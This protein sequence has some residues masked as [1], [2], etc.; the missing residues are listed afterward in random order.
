MLLVFN[1]FGPQF[2]SQLRTEIGRGPH[3]H[4]CPWDATDSPCSYSRPLSATCESGLFFS[5]RQC[6]TL[7]S[8]KVRPLDRGH[9]CAC[10]MVQCHRTPPGPPECAPFSAATTGPSWFVDYGEDFTLFHMSGLGIGQYVKT[11]TV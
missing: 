3:S 4:F 5:A 11:A 10:C 2:A 1:S 8:E 6:S 7:L 9:F